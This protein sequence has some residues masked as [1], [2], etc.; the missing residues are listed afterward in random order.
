MSLIF[1]DTNLFVY[2]LEDHPR[3]AEK[4]GRI[5][6][7]MRERQDRLCTSALTIGE[8]L[9]GPYSRNQEALAKRYREALVPP[10]VEVLPFTA[11]T[12]DYYARI[13][14]DRTIAPA[15]AMQLA[16]AAQAGVNLFLTNDRRLSGKIVPGIQF[17]SDLE[18]DFL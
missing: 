17:I 16:Y 3:L 14:T 5:L 15:E 10:H 13:R 9:A 1:W 6:A 12:A 8:L 4:V 7:R 2:W 11:E 18:I